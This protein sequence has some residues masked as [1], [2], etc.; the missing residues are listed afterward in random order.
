APAAQMMRYDF[1]GPAT[2]PSAVRINATFRSLGVL[3][4]PVIGS[5]LLVT[6]GPALGIFVN[7]AIYLPMTL[8][9]FRTPYT[10]HVRS[11]VR[12]TRVGARDSFRLIGTVRTNR[13]ILTVLVLATLAS[14]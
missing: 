14:I 9:L 2:L 6:L 10:G 8:F 5:L 12:R 1:A 4:G 3:F 11:Q 13:E 7:V